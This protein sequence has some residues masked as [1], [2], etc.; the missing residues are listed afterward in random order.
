MCPV[1]VRLLDVP[2]KEQLK[3]PFRGTVTVELLNQFLDTGHEK[4]KLLY[5]DNK[6]AAKQSVNRESVKNLRATCKPMF[7]GRVENHKEDKTIIDISGKF[8]NLSC[9]C[10]TPGKFVLID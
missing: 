10:M 3:W 1:F 6:Y 2:Y 9:I 5:K 7:D 8:K 4:T